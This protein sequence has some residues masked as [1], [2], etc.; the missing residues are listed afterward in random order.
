MR[1][2]LFTLGFIATTTS[3]FAQTDKDVLKDDP[4]YAQF[5]GQ[6]GF[7]IESDFT[8]R[9]EFPISIDFHYDFE[10]SPIEVDAS[11]LVGVLGDRKN[12][13]YPDN[14]SDNEFQNFNSFEM[15]GVYNFFDKT[16]AKSIRVV[17]GRSTR[18]TASGTYKT[19]YYVRKKGMVRKR[20]GVRTGFY[21]YA[22]SITD[23]DA[24]G[25]SINFSDGTT[26][27][28][29]DHTWNG[30]PSDNDHY[31]FTAER[32]LSAYVGMC[33]H[34]SYGLTLDAG[35]YGKKYSRANV[36]IYADMFV[37][38]ASDIQKL[39]YQGKLYDLTEATAGVDLNTIGFRLGAKKVD[40]I[41]FYSFEVGLK[42]QY[43]KSQFYGQFLIGCSLNRNL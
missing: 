11:F 5:M 40:P 34:R 39:S 7:G 38:L 25:Q 30:K 3:L 29:A 2:Y 36:F 18:T 41:I 4:N 13:F 12:S 6:I 28:D 15:G 8:Y 24:V 22:Q 23:Y 9:S 35:Q 42:P 27:P 43:L 14:L 31:F 1:R 37:D 32:H 16:E 21:R 17:V 26:F 20:F 19:E 33:Y 10:K